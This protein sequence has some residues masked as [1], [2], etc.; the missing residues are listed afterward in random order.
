MKSIW[1]ENHPVFIAGVLYDSQGLEEESEAKIGELMS[2]VRELEETISKYDEKILKLEEENA[3][4]KEKEL[5][6]SLNFKT[7]GEDETRIEK[8][9]SP[10]R[11]GG[12][13]GKEGGTNLASYEV[14]EDDVGF[15]RRIFQT[16]GAKF[17][18]TVKDNNRNH[19]RNNSYAKK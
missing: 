18:Q 1:F 4:L 14:P 10:F 17:L 19:S 2:E 12:G 6:N 7:E 15:G 3:L 9:N 5:Y 16:S 13:G 11:V 8:I